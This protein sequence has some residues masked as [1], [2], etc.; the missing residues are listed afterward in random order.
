MSE[1]VNNFVE[2]IQGLFSQVREL[3]NVQFERLQEICLTTLEKV[4]KGEVPDEFSD[5]LR[6]VRISFYLIFVY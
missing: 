4:I 1:L 5:D 3:E 2:Q 6:D